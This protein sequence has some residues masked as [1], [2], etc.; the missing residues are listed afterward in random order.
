MVSFI[1][2]KSLKFFQWVP[3][4]GQEYCAL[5]EFETQESAQNAC[6]EINMKNR[7]QKTFRVALLK[8]GARLRRTL[9]RKYKGEPD[10][11]SSNLLE[12]VKKEL[13]G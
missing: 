6:R 9:Y 2:I 3:D 13:L 12:D 7:E 5:V 1:T 8:P 10:I 4:L 11:A